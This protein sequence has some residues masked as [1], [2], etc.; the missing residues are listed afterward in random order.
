MNIGILSQIKEKNITGINRV[1]KGTLEELKTR[2][3]QNNYFFLGKTQ[4]LNIDFP[5]IPIVPNGAKCFDLNFTLLAHPLDIVH[6]HYRAFTLNSKIPCARIITIHDLIPLIYKE[7]YPSLYDYFNEEIRK[8]AEQADMIIAVSE[9]TKSDIIKYYGISDKKIRVV[10][11][12]LYPE[13]LFSSELKGKVVSELSNKKFIL[14]VSGVGPHKNQVGLTKA[15]IYYK[16]KHPDS[17]IKL[18][19]V[20]PVRRYHVVREILENNPGYVNDIVMTGF[21]SDDELLWLYQKA[22]AFI[23]VS[24]YEGFG[25]PILEAMS[26]GKAVIASETS[27]LPEVGGDAALYCDPTDIE[28]IYSAIE[29]VIEDETLRGQMERKALLQ[30]GKFSYSKAAEETMEIYKLFQN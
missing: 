8:C 6:S 27:S 20:G 11:N 21:V 29:R 1:S 4:W 18:V 17:D 13:Q 24:F 9:H 16:E 12:G 19:L 22:L 14:S 28:S 15:Y 3:T 5:T 25:L 30:A 26:V 10:Y 2:D 7:W 23:Y